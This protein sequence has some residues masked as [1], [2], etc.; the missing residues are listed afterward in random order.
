MAKEIIESDWYG[1]RT[2][3]RMKTRCGFCEPN[4]LVQ[5]YPEDQ[6]GC[7]RCI[8]EVAWYDKLWVCACTCCDDYEPKNLVVQRKTT[9]KEKVK[10]D[11]KLP[12]PKRTE[13][14]VD[15]SP[16]GDPNGDG[17]V[18]PGDEELPTGTVE[19]DDVTTEDDE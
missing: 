2:V 17:Y 14:H 12:Q 3:S 16:T 7:I 15:G 4:I 10:N 11:R 1:T 18:E 5:N 9:T 19:N 8:K 6:Q 13:D